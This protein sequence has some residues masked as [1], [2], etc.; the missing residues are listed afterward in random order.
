MF[1]LWKKPL[2]FLIAIAVI[3]MMISTALITG[4][5][6]VSEDTATEATAA[7]DT[8]AQDTTAESTAAETSEPSSVNVAAA[9][10]WVTT[11]GI[12]PGIK[13][14][15]AKENITVNILGS[16]QTALRN[17]ETIA[18]TEKTGEFD[19]YLAWEA[20]MPQLKD[21]CEPLDQYLIDADVDLDAF[22]AS[23]YPSVLE[24]ITYDG[25]IYWL[26]IHVNAQLGY[27]RQDIFTNPDEVS[28]FESQYGYALP[29]PDANGAI[30]FED[31]EQ[32]M[33]VARFFTRPD[34]DFWGF[35][36]PGQNVWLTCIF[37]EYLLRTGLEAFDADGHCLWGPAHPENQVQVEEIVTWLQDM[38]VKDKVCTPGNVDMGMTEVNEFYKEG[39]AAMAFSWLVDFWNQDTTPEVMENWNNT[40]PATWAID[41]VNTK[42]EY[43]GF[44]S[45]WCFGLSKEAQDKE[46]AVKFLLKA[47]D[48]ELRKQAQAAGLTCTNG[49]IELTEWS[50]ANGYS[51]GAY[52]IAL[53][54]EGTLWPVS[55][56]S[57]P[58]TETVYFTILSEMSGDLMTGKI[59]PAEFVKNSGDAIEQLMKDAG[60]F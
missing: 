14:E 24:M 8:A 23:L 34:E 3:I 46:A 51:P 37:I 28:A 13:E 17:K 2:N 58:E 9:L 50:V 5:E 47:A 45:L 7:E 21:D 10:G 1:K 54:T 19:I 36:Y 32:F 18:A 42:P 38:V 43:K 48:V 11:D 25:Q 22:K 4:C 57:W 35:T 6:V 15:L 52:G 16:D 60:Y 31:R 30:V 26:P 12:L 41:F 59:T 55:K 33:D 44:M 53:Q 27:A 56:N 49:N 20:I 39:K 40:K 29:Q